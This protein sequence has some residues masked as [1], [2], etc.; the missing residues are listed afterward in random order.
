MKFFKLIIFKKDGT[1]EKL[2][3]LLIQ[4]DSKEKLH[5]LQ[6]WWDKYSYYAYRES[7]GKKKKKIQKKKKKKIQKKKKF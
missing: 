2:Q 3:N 5:W 6:R 1:S 4:R 7:V